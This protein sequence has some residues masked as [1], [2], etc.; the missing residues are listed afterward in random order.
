MSKINKQW[1][2]NNYHNIDD[3]TGVLM[4]KAT[5][6]GRLVLKDCRSE[7]ASGL[8]GL[9]VL[10][11]VFMATLLAAWLFAVGLLCL[12]LLAAVIKFGEWINKHRGTNDDSRA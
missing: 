5:D 8:L 12:P 7:L 10:A 6:H 2:K 3:W 9:A 11:Y 4:T 1:F